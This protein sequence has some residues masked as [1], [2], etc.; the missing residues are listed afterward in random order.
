MVQ[1]DFSVKKSPSQLETAEEQNDAQEQQK[2]A[3]AET[4]RRRAECN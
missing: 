4:M 1:G 2:E 3:D